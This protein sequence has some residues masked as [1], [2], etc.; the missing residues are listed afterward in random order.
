LRPSLLPEDAP[1]VVVERAWGMAMLQEPDGLVRA[2]E[3]IRDR[4]DS[5]DV[6][7]GLPMPLL[8]VVGD[9]DAFLPLDEARSIA[10]AAPDGRLV[11]VEGAGHLPSLERPDEF[12]SALVEFLARLE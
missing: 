12:N 8:V 6:V 2:T 1:T 3:A 4:P 11:V 9:R 10:D 7:R 5:T